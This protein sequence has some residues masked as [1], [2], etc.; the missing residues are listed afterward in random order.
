MERSLS[1]GSQPPKALSGVK[2]RKMTLATTLPE[3]RAGWTRHAVTLHQVRYSFS[4]NLDGV[5]DV[6][7][8]SDFR[9][10]KGDRFSLDRLT[11][12]RQ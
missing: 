7:E 3:F 9:D 6:H 8:P 5:V 1:I 2:A 4:T 10:L 11:T 12:K